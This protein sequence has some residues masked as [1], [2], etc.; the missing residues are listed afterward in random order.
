MIAVHQP[1]IG[2]CCQQ[3]HL[4]ARRDHLRERVN[5]WLPA[6]HR[7]EVGDAGF[8]TAAAHQQIKFDGERAEVEAILEQQAVGERKVRIPA[9]A[10][11]LLK[12]TVSG[13]VIY[14]AERFCSVR[15]NRKF[16]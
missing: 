8:R 14:A 9:A 3:R 11:H 5:A 1:Q 4:E 12:P 15:V 2:P 10:E 7:V 6:R 13:D 16:S